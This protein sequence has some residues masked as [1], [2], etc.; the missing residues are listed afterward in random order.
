MGLGP[1]LYFPPLGLETSSVFSVI[2]SSF[3]IAGTV[4]LPR[5]L[6]TF[7]DSTL[8]YWVINVTAIYA[9]W[10]KGK[11]GFFAVVTSISCF[12]SVFGSSSR[13]GP[14]PCNM[15]IG[16]FYWCPSLDSRFRVLSDAEAIVVFG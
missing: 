10:I 7:P 9:S 6:D 2:N 15:S 5:L 12:F 1:R 4:I 3:N 11:L 16:Y 13:S 14:Q 8:L